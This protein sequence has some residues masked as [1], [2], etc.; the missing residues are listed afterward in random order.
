MK[1]AVILALALALALS[2]AA[3]ARAAAF[4]PKTYCFYTGGYGDWAL[5]YVKK[6][7]AVPTADG[8]VNMYSVNG[9]YILNGWAS[10]PVTGTMHYVASWGYAHFA[11]SGNFFDGSDVWTVGME[12]FS[13]TGD[14]YMYVSSGFS[15][16]G[17]WYDYYFTDY[18][19]NYS[20]P[21]NAPREQKAS[22]AEVLKPRFEAFKA[23]QAQK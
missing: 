3:G 22:L 9:E 15:G 4:P 7:G 20:V 5:L 10:V 11:L 13:D 14:M 2:L 1:R 16:S 19:Q 8:S 17:A 23:Q 12:C 6:I 21:Y 18:C